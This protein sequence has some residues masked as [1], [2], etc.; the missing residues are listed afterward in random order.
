VAD[1]HELPI[2]DASVTNIVLVDVIH[3]LAEP[4]RFLREAQRV[5]T[6][7]GRLVLV[8]PAIT[9]WSWVF[10]RFL[11]PERVDFSADPFSEVDEGAKRDPYDGN[12]AVPTLLFDE[13]SDRL[14]SVAPFLRLR[15]KRYLSLFAYPLSGGFRPWSLVPEAI[16]E[17]L[18]R[19]EERLLPTLGKW[20]A[21][22][23]LVVLERSA[24]SESSER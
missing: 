16:V 19:I 5:L 21:F 10:Y 22:R 24:P 7:R 1:A 18:L 2:A 4:G 20:M 15:H 12:Q 23:M 3:H 6:P 9:P 11:H 17:P 14:R 8:E 13:R